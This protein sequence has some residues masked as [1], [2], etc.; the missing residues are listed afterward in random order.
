MHSF[1]KK[2][3]TA[4]GL[5]AIAASMLSCNGYTDGGEPEKTMDVTFHIVAEGFADTRSSFTWGDNEIRDIQIVVTE[6]DGSVFEVLYSDS[7]SDLSFTGVVGRRYRIWAAANP[8]GKVEVRNLQDFTTGT[9]SI[10]KSEI[11]ASGIPMFNGPDGQEILLAGNSGPVTVRLTR[12]LAR[13]DLNVDTRLLDSGSLFS[14]QDVRMFNAIN[15]YSPFTSSARQEHTGR[16]EYTFDTASAS[17][18]S[19]L[20]RGG[21]ISL[22]AFENMQGTLLPGNTDPW[23][24]VPASIGD[25]GDYC[26]YLEVD[27]TYG[28]SDNEVT[29]RMYLGKDATTNFD[30]ER[31]TVYRVTLM[32]T[33]TEIR[34]ER[35]SWKVEAEPW[36]DIIDVELI[37]NPSTLELE[38]GGE[39]SMISSY[40]LYTYENGDKELDEALSYWTAGKNDLKVIDAAIWTPLNTDSR[41]D[42]VE[43]RGIASGSASVT[44]SAYYDGIDYSATC[45]ITVR[46]E[47]VYSEESEFELTIEPESITISEGQDARFTAMLT[48]R[49]Y[50]TVDGIRIS[51][52]PIST[53]RSNVTTLADWTVTTGDGNVSNKGSG[54]F[55]WSYGPGTSE[56]SASYDG[57]SATAGIVTESHIPSITYVW[58]IEI[59]DIA[60]LEV[61]QSENLSV[62]RYTD[63]YSDGVLIERDNVGE[64]IPNNL[65]F[66]GFGLYPE[67][68]SYSNPNASLSGGGIITGLQPGTCTVLAVLREDESVYSTLDVEI[69]KQDEPD[70]EPVLTISVTE[71]DT[72]GGNGY[73]IT[74]LYDDGRGNVSDVTAEAFYS[75]SFTGGIPNGLLG[76][77]GSELLAEDWWGLSGSWVTAGPTYTL[78]LSYNRLSVEISGTMH[79]YTHATVIPEKP[80][81]YYSEIEDHGWSGPAAVATLSGSE[82]TEVWTS[83]THVT[84]RDKYTLSNGYLGLGSD[85]PFHAYFTDPSNGYTR[86]GDSDF[87][88][89]TNVMTLQVSI[90]P[91]FAQYAE[92]VGL[93][94]STVYSGEFL[95]SAGI[96]NIEE[97]IPSF[98][99]N[100]N[101]DIWYEDYKGDA[102]QLTFPNGSTP[103]NEVISLSSGWSLKSDW[104]DTI[105]EGELRTIEINVNGFSASWQWGHIGSQ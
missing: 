76:W 42:H 40:F 79:G 102:H 66:F 70:P 51:E 7:P 74:L 11:A 33:E 84:D 31:N 68:M 9:R 89:E 97:G 21:T 49:V 104:T 101:Q 15:T 64:T 100:I 60:P 26:T 85:I 80:V 81:W 41:M 63:T 29:Y 14:V 52:T 83:D 36:N 3:L 19:T 35:G 54:V 45:E 82:T 78:T 43:L 98:I 37:L 86:E 67:D 90:Y 61:G 12:M 94:E 48:E 50:L 95:G 30:V 56:V 65:V 57:Y 38:V 32:P 44:A 24:K 59:E 13:V 23:S 88:I 6:E 72:W 53:N 27:C 25:A 2:T 5:A 20:N 1:F 69:I 55:S 18:V 39:F 77:N 16:I 62:R 8:G 73:P 4:A 22:Y 92:V 28:Y 99:I 103:S 17:D 87:T 47:P 71:L 10:T 96:R 105:Y 46:H 93:V 58:R 75:F 34:G 91:E